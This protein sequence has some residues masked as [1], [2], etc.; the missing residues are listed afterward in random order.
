M[1]EFKLK[2]KL[3]VFCLALAFLLLPRALF[4]QEIFF[5]SVDKIVEYR[6]NLHEWD[7]Y[8]LGF[9]AAHNFSLALGYA[10]SNWQVNAFPG[11]ETEQSSSNNAAFSKLRYEYHLKIY[12]SLGYFIGSSGGYLLE[13]D[14]ANS[15]QTSY[16]WMVPG[17][18]VGLTWNA[19]SVLRLN[20][21]LDCYPERWKHLQHFDSEQPN[22][23]SV[24]AN[25]MDLFF[26]VDY[27]YKLKQAIRLE[28]HSRELKH[29][30]LRNSS[31]TELDFDVKKNDKIVGISILYHLL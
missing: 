23:V 27:F 22:K 6:K 20:F 7:K 4:A 30:H 3:P 11:M 9:R 14:N 26:A 18:L 19:G 2:K 8:V 10:R 1:E 25:V 13:A 21:G 16:S 31:G 24:T 15:V 28:Y 12:R 17:I 29:R 5:N